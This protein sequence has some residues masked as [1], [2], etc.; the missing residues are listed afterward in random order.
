MTLGDR[1]QGLWR[2]TDFLVN[3]VMLRCWLRVAVSQ[4]GCRSI[5]IRKLEFSL[6][7]FGDVQAIV[8]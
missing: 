6:V 2:H 1:F 5:P 4:I 8:N 3:F 7:C